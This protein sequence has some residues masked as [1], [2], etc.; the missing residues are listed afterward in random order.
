M[1]IMEDKQ[2][3]GK[4]SLELISRMIQNSRKNLR[5]GSGNV[6]LLWGYLCAVTSLA[7]YMLLTAVYSPAWNWLWLVMLVVVSGQTDGKRGKIM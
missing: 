3:N 4:E 7:I 5:I 2:L 1:K 6:F